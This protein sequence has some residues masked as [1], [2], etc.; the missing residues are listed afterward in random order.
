MLNKMLVGNA[1]NLYAIKAFSLRCRL[2]QLCFKV[3][4]DVKALS[5][6]KCSIVCNI[7]CR[8]V[9]PQ[10]EILNP[11]CIKG[12]HPNIAVIERPEKR[13]L[14][15]YSIVTDNILQ[16]PVIIQYV[17]IWILQFTVFCLQ[18]MSIASIIICLLT[19]VF[20]ANV[21]RFYVD[22]LLSIWV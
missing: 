3:A 1:K 9:V 10:K 7:R 19:L 18:I 12:Q 8:Q 5:T 16:R 22:W 15:S 11:M 14:R 17:R 20:L 6:V 13:C 21:T 4:S 2:H